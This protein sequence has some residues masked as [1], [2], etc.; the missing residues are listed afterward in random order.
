MSNDNKWQRLTASGITSDN[1]WQQVAISANFSFFRIREE[2]TT[3]HMKE[4]LKRTLKRPLKRD[5]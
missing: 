2:L 5:F 4:N 3:K 1:Q